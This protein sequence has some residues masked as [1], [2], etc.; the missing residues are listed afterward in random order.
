MRAKAGIFIIICLLLLVGTVAAV[1]PD[2]VVITGN[3]SWIVAGHGLSTYT[4]TVKNNSFGVPN[5]DISFSVN[6][7][8]GTLTPATKKTDSN[9]IASSI[10]TVG[11]K[12]GTSTISIRVQYNG[13]TDGIFD[14]T[15]TFDQNI[16]HD[17]PYNVNFDHLNEAPV[18]NV[19]PFNMS[20]TD[21]W[22]NRIDNLNPNETHTIGLHI[23][24]PSPDNCS[25]VGNGLNDIYPTLDSNGNLSV[26]VKLTS[27]SGNNYILMDSFG[28][29]TEKLESI[30]AVATGIPYSMTGSIS[31]GGILPVN[32]EIPANGVDKFT[33]NYFLYDVYKNPLQNRS[34][35]ISTNLTDELTPKS[36]ITNSLGQVQITYGPKISVLTANITAVAA[37][38]SS[39]TNSLD[40]NFVGSNVAS[41]LFLVVTPQTMAS[42]DSD[43]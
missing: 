39:V 5:A 30:Q 40:A 34:I 8:L 9:G 16:D 31:N 13:G 10:F 41:N 6:N 42:R 19:T 21:R 33:I 14:T 12:S 15:Y 18:T 27:K 23:H 29:I 11:T 7:T 22:G 43:P 38:N 2:N 24:G 17:S 35:W 1:I 25:F 3:S 20:V 36:Y 32:N 4:V 26:N 28:S 37:E